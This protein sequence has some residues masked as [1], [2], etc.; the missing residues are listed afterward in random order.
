MPIGYKVCHVVDGEYRSWSW[1]IHGHT[2]PYVIGGSVSRR[3]GC[4]PLSL[5]KT[6]EDAY[7]FISHWSFVQFPMVAILKV[8]YTPSRTKRLFFKG[9][10][11]EIYKE[12]TPPGTIFAAH[13]VPISVVDEFNQTERYP[14]SFFWGF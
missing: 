10:D 11:R 9:R 4:G 14:L 1:H 12:E 5:F 3:K 13:I 8:S 2:T 7:N 6:E